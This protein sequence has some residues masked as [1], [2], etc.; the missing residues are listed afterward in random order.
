MSLDPTLLEIKRGFGYI[1][2]DADGAQE[3]LGQLADDIIAVRDAYGLDAAEQRA[4]RIIFAFQ[5]AQ[6]PNM[7]PEEKLADIKQFIQDLD[8]A[9]PTITFDIEPEDLTSGRLWG[10]IASDLKGLS[11]EWDNMLPVS[12]RGPFSGIWGDV[13][14]FN[15]GVGD[16]TNTLKLAGINEGFDVV[17]ANLQE[18]EKFGTLD[19]EVATRLYQEIGRL[20]AIDTNSI[21]V[22]NS[23]DI[24]TAS[25]LLSYLRDINV[26]RSDYLNN[27][28][29]RNWRNPAAPE[30]L[31]EDDI[32]FEA[33]AAAT[34]ARQQ[35]RADYIAH[36]DA[37]RNLRNA[38]IAEF[39]IAIP[40][41]GFEVEFDL[42]A[43]QEGLDN[44]NTAMATVRTDWVT[45]MGT[46]D[47]P[48]TTKD[49]LTTD[50]S[51]E[52][53]VEFIE[54]TPA[55]QTAFANSMT[56]AM[57]EQEMVAYIQTAYLHPELFELETLLSDTQTSMESAGMRLAV[58]TAFPSEDAL[59]AATGMLSSVQA[60]MSRQALHIP[61][62][63]DVGQLPSP[64]PGPSSPATGISLP[65]DAGPSTEVNI[66]NP[67]STNLAQDAAL[68][69]IIIGG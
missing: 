61:V 68:A 17:I 16:M 45:T 60:S 58:M 59:W 41:T 40:L 21:A 42:G 12:R 25:D 63:F 26:V 14:Q 69:G 46:L 57:E 8:R 39:S 48:Q 55:E 11:D 52:A 43:A 23:T 20:A 36:I 30:V 6:D 47:V 51:L 10:G 66:F 31:P 64:T 27:E 18:F 49:A 19:H 3:A 35:E 65:G 28:G 29:R 9:T 34:A 32:D 62:V 67:Q 54:A 5:T 38:A 1:E 44:F 22:F 53:K 13:D 15:R 7:T 24:Q 2:E 37:V 33:I 50:L 56:T 4:F